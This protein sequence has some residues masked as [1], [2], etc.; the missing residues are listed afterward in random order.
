MQSEG[1]THYGVSNST[2]P[3]QIPVPPLSRVTP[4]GAW[5]GLRQAITREYDVVWPTIHAVNCG[6]AYSGFKSALCMERRKRR[7][8]H[9]GDLL[10][11]LDHPCPL[12]PCA[13]LQSMT[14]SNLATLCI[15]RSVSRWLGHQ[16]MR[17]SALLAVAGIFSSCVAAQEAKVLAS[18]DVAASIDEYEYQSDAARLLKESFSPY[19][20]PDSY[21]MIPYL[22]NRSVMFSGG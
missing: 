2:A 16:D 3:A 7:L 21:T 10:G 14:C 5:Q 12:H 22:L 18:D 6:L 19:E 4:S 8:Q 13:G 1:G 9:L 15:L 17:V 20:T 11:I